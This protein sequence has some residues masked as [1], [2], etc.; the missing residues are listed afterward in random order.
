MQQKLQQFQKIIEKYKDET[1]FW[2]SFNCYWYT[3]KLCGAEAIKKF[4][5]DKEHIK[6][7]FDREKDIIKDLR[8]DPLDIFTK[9]VD[10]LIIRF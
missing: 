3:F 2:S 7:Y 5:E 1:T 6:V 10:N 8:V 4:Y 9:G